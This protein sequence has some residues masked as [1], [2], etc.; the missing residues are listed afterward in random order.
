MR[1]VQ[2]GTRRRELVIL[3][4]ALVLASAFPFM[5]QTA[6]AQPGVWTDT[7]AD[8]TKVFSKSNAEVVGGNARIQVLASDYNWQKQGVVVDRGGPSDPD[9]W[10]SEPW[11]L[12]GPDGVYRMWYLGVDGSNDY[13]IM[14]ATSWDGYNW[15]KQGVVLPYGFSGTGAD[16][17]RVTSPCVIDEGTQYRMYYT[18]VNGADKRVILMAVSSDGLTWTYDGLAV[19]RG[20]VGENDVIAYE[21]V[22]ED[23]GSY[24]M[25]Y[26]GFSAGG[27]YQIF[28]ATSPD[29]TTWTK[30]GLVMPIG[31]PGADD[32]ISIIKNVVV[33]NSTGTYRMWYGAV[34]SVWRILYAESPD[35]VDWTDRRGIVLS[36][37]GPGDLDEVSINVGSVRLPV[38]M[39]GWMYY[40]GRDASGTDR[41]FIA[42]MGSLGNLT[43][44]T[45]TKSAGYDWDTLFLNKTIVPNEAEVLVS[46]LNANT[47][48]PYPGYSDLSGT[49]IDLSSIPKADNSIRL[50]AD[51]YGTTTD[52]PLLEDW[53]VTWDDIAGPLFGGLLTATDDGT[54]GS[55][56]LN[57]NPA[58]DPST[59]I[60]YNI[61]IAATSMGQNF[62]APNYT[63]QLTTYQ[64]GGLTDGVQYYFIVRAQD[65][66]GYE[67][68]NVIERSAMP[69]TPIDSTAP[70]FAGLQTATDSGTG[71]TV[72]LTWNAGTDPD[73][74]E[75]NS[76]PSNPITYNVYYAGTSGGQNFLVPDATTQLT[77]VD[78]IG[79]TDGNTYYFV[80]RAED[81]VGNEEGNIIERSARPTT[82][83]DSTPPT[84]SGLTTATDLGT[85]GTVGLVWS[86]ADDPD[87][88]ECNNDPSLPL[89]YNIYYSKVPGSQDFLN[90]NATTP[91][92]FI[93]ISG[94][95]NGVFH[96]FVVRAEDA[97]GNEET[98]LIER[99]AIPTTP[100]DDTPPNFAGLQGAVDAQTGGTVT[101]NWIAATDPDTVHSNSDPSLPITYYIFYST[102]SGGQNFMSP[103]ASATGT[104]T[105]IT[106]L[107]NGVQYYFVVRA[108]DSAG[109]QETNTVERTSLPT[110]PTDDTPP[111]FSGLDTAT[112]TQTDEDVTLT[113]SPATDPDTVHCNSDPTLPITYSVY[114]S[115]IPGNQNFLL[116]NTTTQNTNIVITGLQNGVTYYFVVRA[117]DGVG[118]QETNVVERSAMPTTPVDSEPPVFSG[119]VLA[120]DPQTGGA[121]DLIWAAAT[122]P[123]L[124][125][126]NSDPSIPITYNVYYSTT[127]GIDPQITDAVTQSTSIQITGL[128]DG[129]T[130]YFMVR[131]QDSAG[132][133]ETNTIEMSA[134]PTT[135]IDTTPPQ[136][137]GLV[138]ATDLATGGNV[139]LTWSDATDLDTIE[140]NSDPTLPL[141]YNVYIATASGGQNFLSP[142]QTVS[143]T[144]ATVPE[145][146]NGVRY[147]FVVRAVD[148]AGNEESNTIEHS[149]MPTTPID[150]TPPTFGG[151]NLVVTDN[152]T[153]DITLTWNIATDPDDPECNS[154]P[155]TPITYNIYVS[156]N[157][158]F[159]FSQPT[160]TTS[161]QQYPFLDLERGVTYYF[162]VRAEDNA[163]NEETNTVTKT[164]ELALLDEGFDFLDYW[165][166][167]LIVVIV[168]LLVVI[169]L[170]ARRRK[171][172]EPVKEEEE[173]EEVPTE[174]A[175]VEEEQSG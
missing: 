95:D 47:L 108:R 117:S 93:D 122:D 98:N 63:T 105:D 96:Y 162:I 136:F 154:D 50:R 55:V 28:Q 109:N 76:D 90:P 42:T 61:Y 128:Q 106:G 131:A 104:T 126:C 147:Y 29:A 70:T 26:S 124:I 165:W 5:S 4:S 139:S 14:Y 24:K 34:G 48:R 36:E 77:N 46:V 45:I 37:G 52:N 125:E 174:E 101:L 168:L 114:I 65:S 175:P 173:V 18:G 146:Q 27:N 35:G 97:A 89:S 160:A 137:N 54:G 158:T 152:G 10:V 116:P 9:R 85:G 71:G 135:P 16:S 100:L 32:G 86:T 145:L 167:I 23:A 33:K 138:S 67:E 41:S 103:D 127:P 60:D 171:G 87:T 75:C 91:N 11:V 120:D 31:S 81:A 74:L 73:T 83:V 156:E 44:T 132:N 49:V 57:W 159:D 78:I 113:W 157:P 38:N 94:L 20:G 92:T 141:Q 164:A 6:T 166:I 153:G 102:T 59:P 2:T 129:T 170:L 72:A 163:G 3:L 84:F 82:P 68:T 25:W 99:S 64:V 143:V 111:V 15:E 130:Y 22:L 1:R 88:L 30:Q 21:S 144:Q 133:E 8:E 56:T 53:A 118:N 134:M 58:T 172:E 123:D 12:K 80:V 148:A 155:S 7:F 79:L 161:Q 149:A 112:D 13:R 121:V 151:L 62:L 115:T 40:M 17:R 169:A 150:S 19:N 43:S 142:N 107:T 110:T 51:F 39:A 140:C 119:L 66:L 69:T